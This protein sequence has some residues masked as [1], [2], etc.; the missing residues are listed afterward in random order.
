[1]YAALNLPTI[2]FHPLNNTRVFWLRALLPVGIFWTGMVCSVVPV[3]CMVFD[4]YVEVLLTWPVWSSIPT[5]IAIQRICK[6][7]NVTI[8]QVLYK[9]NIWKYSVCYFDILDSR[10]GQMYFYNALGINISC[11]EILKHKFY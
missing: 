4:H 9:I 8:Y 2:Y 6:W 5:L 11:A 3:Q 10:I 7:L 1:M